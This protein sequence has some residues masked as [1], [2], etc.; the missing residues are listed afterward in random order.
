MERRTTMLL[1]PPK[2]S[3]MN[4]TRRTWL[5]GLAA[6]SMLAATPLLI[7]NALAMAERPVAP[8]LHRAEGSVLL[9]NQPARPGSLVNPGDSLATGAD[10]TAIF[11]IDRDA[12]LLR[13]NSKVEVIGGGAGTRTMRVLTGKMLSVFGRGE[14]KITL[15]TAT[16]GIRGTGVYV[17]AERERAYVCTCYGEVEI[18]A[19]ADPKIRETVRTRHHDAP[20]FIL[21]ATPGALIQ[22]APVFNHTDAELIMLEALVGRIP[23]FYSPWR[24]GSGVY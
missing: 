21:A 22:P 9:N 2:E 24:E 5:T 17:E 8:G 14:K 1:T 20:R 11:V 3:P 13:P 7:R 6:G 10:G 19:V 23:P 16:L 15:P 4:P 12:F 18:Q